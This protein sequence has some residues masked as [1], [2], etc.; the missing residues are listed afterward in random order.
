MAPSRQTV[1]AAVLEYLKASGL[2]TSLLSQV[3]HGL[4]PQDP[5][6]PPADCRITRL[7]SY[8]TDGSFEVSVSRL[9]G[10]TDHF[11]VNQWTTVGDLKGLIE[12]RL[13][14]PPG[15]LLLLKGGRELK[16]SQECLAACRVTF[17]H[18]GLE[19]LRVE[20]RHR[21]DAEQSMEISFTAAAGIPEGSIISLRAGNKG[22]QVPLRFGQPHRFPLKKDDANPFKVDVFSQF[23]KAR[24]V[25]RPT[26]DAYQARIE[27]DTGLPVG[28]IDFEAYDLHGMRERHYKAP[29]TG[30]AQSR[31]SA[32]AQHTVLASRYLDEHGLVQYL[33]GLLQSV[34]HEKPADPY[35]YMIN[36]L[37]TAQQARSCESAALATEA[38]SSSASVDRPGAAAHTGPDRPLESAGS[39]GSEDLPRLLATARE[40]C[41]RLRQTAADCERREQA[42]LQAQ[43]DLRRQLEECRA[44]LA[45]LQLARHSA[46]EHE[47]KLT[48]RLDDTEAEEVRLRQRCSTAE[49]RCRQV[50]GQMQASL[51]AALIDVARLQER[52]DG[53]E[54]R[55][56]AALQQQEQLRAQIEELRRREQRAVEAEARLTLRLDDA[57]AEEGRLRTELRSRGSMPPG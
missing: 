30:T 13:E 31:A 1:D 18:A 19:A 54:R 45:K 57:E 49:G 14:I 22:R 20:A 46:L 41:Q 35:Q 26:V 12:H 50:E 4:A 5:T 32:R 7:F 23:G 56:Q 47:A 15:E 55:E 25:L 44:E 17:C 6:E 16:N 40:E 42:A 34:I 29:A 27:D 51:A 9:S 8:A 28:T 43:E 38:V 48:L 11:D 10:A 24:L 33:Q 3:K 36:Q 53:S 52:A 37:T 21:P 2:E 39:A